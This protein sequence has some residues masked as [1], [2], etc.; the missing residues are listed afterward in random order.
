MDQPDPLPVFRRQFLQLATGGLAMSL[1]TGIIHKAVASPTSSHAALKPPVLRP[2]D[3]V[4][5]VA[6]ASNVYEP[7]DLQ[8]ARETME[9]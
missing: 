9:Q 1:S 7:E 2:G 3:T 8:I 5:M 4:G 6:P